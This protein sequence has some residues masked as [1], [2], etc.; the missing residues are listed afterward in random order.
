MI[1]YEIFVVVKAIS[2]LPWRYRFAAFFCKGD[3]WTCLTCMV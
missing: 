2:L 1:Y 3:Y